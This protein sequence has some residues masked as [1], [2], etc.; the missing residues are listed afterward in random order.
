[1]KAKSFFKQFKKWSCCCIVLA[2]VNLNVPSCDPQAFED[3]ASGQLKSSLNSI[4]TTLVQKL[5]YET[6]DLPE[7]TSY[8]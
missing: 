4:F 7:T 6:F 8:Y 2:A 1:M 5:I 3:A